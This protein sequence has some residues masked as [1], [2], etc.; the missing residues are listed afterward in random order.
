MRQTSLPTE[1]SGHLVTKMDVVSQYLKL[2]FCNIILG[3]VQS[4]RFLFR[5]RGSYLYILIYNIN[6]PKTDRFKTQK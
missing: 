2:T 5:I 1:L 6:M 4:Q 3:I